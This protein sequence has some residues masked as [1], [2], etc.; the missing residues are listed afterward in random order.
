MPFLGLRRLRLA[1]SGAALAVVLTL[2]GYWWWRLRA[3]SGSESGREPR[4]PVTTKPSGSTTRQV[5]STAAF[6]VAD[7]ATSGCLPVNIV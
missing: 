6:I 2:L 4:S 5:T 3:Y 1:L 7:D